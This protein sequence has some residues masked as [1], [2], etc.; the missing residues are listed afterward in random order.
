MLPIRGETGTGNR[1]V[2]TAYGNRRVP[3]PFTLG[4]RGCRAGFHFRDTLNL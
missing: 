2:E 4:D 3:E 1:K